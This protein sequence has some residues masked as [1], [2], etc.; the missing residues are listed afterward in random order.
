M[1]RYI[2][3]TT[4]IAVAVDTAVRPESFRTWVCDRMRSG[5][6]DAVLSHPKA[7]RVIAVNDPD[8]NLHQP[9]FLP[10][11]LAAFRQAAVVWS[12][13]DVL[14]VRPDLS[15]EQA[16]HVL[17]QAIH[18]HDTQHGIGW[19]TFEYFATCLYGERPEK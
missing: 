5:F 8:G 13:S 17:H 3:L 9:P 16:A 19:D 11:L 7:V 6:H 10:P 4:T 1:T 2:E 14:D 15:D 18:Q 12:A